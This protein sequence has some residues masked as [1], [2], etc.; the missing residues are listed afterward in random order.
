MKCPECGNEEFREENDE[1]YCT[2][3]GLVISEDYNTVENPY[4][5][6]S[7]TIDN[8]LHLEMKMTNI[9]KK[10]NYRSRSYERF[11]KFK[12]NYYDIF[13][14]VLLKNGYMMY[15][16]PHIFYNHFRQWYQHNS[17]RIGNKKRVD[18][19]NWFLM[20]WEV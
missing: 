5:E 7:L 12:Q 3:C 2:K 6:N 20:E 1:K 18:V 10:H 9:E 19:I 16:V 14:N 15:D 8:G 11:N 4:G 13:E 17:K